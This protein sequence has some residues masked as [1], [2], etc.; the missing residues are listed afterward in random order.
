MART[1]RK[2]T[3][4]ELKRYGTYAGIGGLAAAVGIAIYYLVKPKPEPEPPPVPPVP[5]VPPIP[6]EWVWVEE[7][8]STVTVGSAPDALWAWYKE[9]KVS[10]ACGQAPPPEWLWYK[11]LGTMVTVGQAPVPQWV[12]FKEIR[13]IV[14]AKVEVIGYTLTLKVSPSGAGTISVSPDKDYYDPG[15]SVS[16]TAYPKSG[17]TFVSFQGVPFAMLN[18]TPVTMDR[19]RT[20]TAVFKEAITEISFRF[21]LTGEPSEWWAQYPGW[22]IQYH[23]ELYGRYTDWNNGITIVTDNPTGNIYVYGKTSPTYTF[24]DGA[25]YYYNWRNNTITTIYIP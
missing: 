19:N 6:P 12:W 18:P 3:K 10:V 13:T 25:S 5:P 21:Y 24:V 20:V 22:Y 2:V 11:E 16:I 17:Y 7:L 15:E 9:L 23:G 4:T 14:K 8:A 1:K